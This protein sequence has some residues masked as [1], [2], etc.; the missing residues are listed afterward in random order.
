MIGLS[1]FFANRSESVT[2]QLPNLKMEN[3]ESRESTRKPIRADS[4]DS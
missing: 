3:Y 1:G 4:W 2:I